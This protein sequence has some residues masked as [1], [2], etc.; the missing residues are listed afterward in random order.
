MCDGSAMQMGGYT[1]II[2]QKGAELKLEMG[3]EW[4]I[5]RGRDTF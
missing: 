4:D 3:P 5:W 1:A 2:D